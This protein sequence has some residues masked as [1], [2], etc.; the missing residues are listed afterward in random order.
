MEVTRRECAAH[1]GTYD[2]GTD[3]ELAA[4]C[5]SNSVGLYRDSVKTYVDGRHEGDLLRRIGR[6]ATAQE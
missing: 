3:G 2:E 6:N 1:C 5:L 4:G